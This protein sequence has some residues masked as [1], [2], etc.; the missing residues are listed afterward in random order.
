MIY[1]IAT[2]NEVICLSKHMCSTSCSIVSQQ[3]MYSYTTKF[4]ERNYEARARIIHLR[5][6]NIGETFNLWLRVLSRLLYDF[7]NLLRFFIKRAFLVHFIVSSSKKIARIIFYYF[8]KL[9]MLI[10]V[11]SK[12]IY[13][14]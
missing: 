6:R 11:I 13:T 10:S 7:D 1:S 8:L 3:P 4:D 9:V 5:L 14:Q 12:R 2:R